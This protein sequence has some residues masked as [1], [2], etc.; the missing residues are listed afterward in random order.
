MKHLPVGLLDLAYYIT[1]DYA[2]ECDFNAFKMWIDF[3]E[4]RRITSPI[5]VKIISSCV[6]ILQ[7]F[8]MSKEKISIAES[9][10]ELAYINVF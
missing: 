6:V 5:N 1:H 7:I 4:H 10:Y 2:H 8:K 3:R 9:L